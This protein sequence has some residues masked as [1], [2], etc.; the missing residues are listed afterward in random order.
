MTRVQNL[1][2][3]AISILLLLSYIQEEVGLHNNYT[4]HTCIEFDAATS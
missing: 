3:V 1:S 2:F 4:K